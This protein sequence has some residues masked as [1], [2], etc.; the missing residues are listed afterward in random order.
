L[1]FLALVVYDLTLEN[2]STKFVAPLGLSS[3]IHSAIAS[4]TGLAHI[5]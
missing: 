1:S 3:A 4:N 2:F 5:I